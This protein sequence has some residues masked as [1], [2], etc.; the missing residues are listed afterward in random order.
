MN[1]VSQA[2][3]QLEGT[4]L[5]DDH[6]PQYSVCVQEAAPIIHYYTP[7]R[8]ITIPMIAA[9]VLK[10]NSTKK[11]CYRSHKDMVPLVGTSYA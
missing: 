6:H 7:L 8:L 5:V 3:C 1:M 4:T 11:C 9:C 2:K 10:S